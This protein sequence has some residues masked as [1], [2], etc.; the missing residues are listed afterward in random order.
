M[1]TA[2]RLID[3]PTPAT[4]AIRLWFGRDGT[5]S[6]TITREAVTRGPEPGRQDRAEPLARPTRP[7]AEWTQMR[8]RLL[9]ALAVIVL[10]GCSGAPP[11][12]SLTLT[13]VGTHATPTPTPEPTTTPEPTATEDALVAACSGTPVPGAAPYAGKVHPLV[14]VDT[15]ADWIDASYAINKKWRDGKWTSPV[16]LVVC[17][18]DP[19]KAKVRVGSC[20]RT[21]K[22]TDGVVGELVRYRYKSTLRVV[23]A[24]TGK[25]LQSKVLLGSIPPCGGS[26]SKYSSLDLSVKPPWK[27]FGFEV[28]DSQ[29][30]KYATA[31]STQA[32]K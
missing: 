20:G 26:A 11:D 22:R 21:W 18:P 10:A 25:T 28:T 14:V 4:G 15:W 3:R 9:V 13:P 8:S 7:G 1:A 23:V 12:P 32:V 24:S 17:A 30:S 27:I 6:V 2:R 31:V 5:R 29:V 16:Q 19:Q